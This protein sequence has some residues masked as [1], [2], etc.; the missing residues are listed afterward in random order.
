MSAVTNFKETYTQTVNTDKRQLSGII[1]EVIDK[2]SH[3]FTLPYI[4]SINRLL[5]CKDNGWKTHTVIE[6]FLIF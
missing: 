6:V 1:P 3:V 4:S 2:L 5:K